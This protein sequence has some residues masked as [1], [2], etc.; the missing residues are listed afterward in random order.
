MTYTNISNKTFNYNYTIILLCIGYFIDF[1]DLSIFG[2]GYVELIKQQ[3]G[4][5]DPTQIQ[6]LYLYITNWYTVGIFLGSIIF[7]I[8]GDK[9]GRV[10]VIRYSILLYSFSILAS[11][12]IKSIPLFCFIRFLT[13]AGLACEFATSSVLISEIVKDSYRSHK[14][15]IL[16]YGCGILGGL[17]SLIFSF[18]SWQIM[19]L[20]GG[21]SGILL[22]LGRKKVYES[23]LFENIYR[24]NNIDKGN[25]SIIISNSKTF[26][27]TLKLFLLITPFNLIISIIFIFP[28]LMNL[29]QDLSS[30]IKTILLGFFLGGVIG[31]LISSPIMNAIKSYTKYLTISFILILFILLFPLKYINDQNLFIYCIIIGVIGGSYPPIWIQLVSRSYGTNLRNTA[32]NSLFAL[33]RLSGI[34]FNI[35]ISYSLANMHLGVYYLKYLI[36]LVLTFAILSLFTIKDNYNSKLDYLER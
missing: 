6:Q 24:Q 3:F 14:I 28:S 7:G 16:L 12:F 2:S 4:V 13:G 33:G 27:K 26:L 15:S 11:L 17:T 18:I 35:I 29:N 23:I 1:Y 20:F 22:Y 19:F 25:I 10:Y 30:A 32:S 36:I 31:L 9:F 5:I 21:I 8:L 34:F